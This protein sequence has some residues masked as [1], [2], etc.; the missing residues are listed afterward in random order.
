MFLDII[1]YSVIILFNKGFLYKMNEE[2]CSGHNSK[3]RSSIRYFILSNT[4][5]TTF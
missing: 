1:F 4:A 3:K 5:V 2:S